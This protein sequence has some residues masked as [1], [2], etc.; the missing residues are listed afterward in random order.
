MKPGRLT[1]RDEE[2]NARRFY[3]CY[4]KK[5]G[6][7]ENFYY[8]IQ[9]TL[10][11]GSGSVHDFLHEHLRVRRIVSRRVLHNATDVQKYARVEWCR[12]M[13]VKFEAR[14]SRRVYDI[15]TGDES[16][17]SSSKVSLFHGLNYT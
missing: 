16:W 17:I 11:I 5:R 4:G 10:Q 2:K 14:S 6:S 7:G 8:E 3:G 1:L 13:I 12:D 15:D 9:H